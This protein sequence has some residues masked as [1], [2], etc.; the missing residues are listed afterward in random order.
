MPRATYAGRS[1]DVDTAG[2]LLRPGDWS[3]EVAQAMAADY[4]LELTPDHWSVIEFVRNDTLETGASPGPLRITRSTGISIKDLYRLFPQGPGKLIP[5]ISG[6]A[7]CK[8]P[9]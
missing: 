2:C 5:R 4:S 7:K 6:V 9:L 3:P 1:V 8:A